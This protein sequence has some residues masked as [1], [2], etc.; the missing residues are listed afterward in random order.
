MCKLILMSYFID[1]L[2]VFALGL[3][4]GYC[5]QVGVVVG[6]CFARRVWLEWRD[7]MQVGPCCV[8][9]SFSWSIVGCL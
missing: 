8:F 2:F 7:V 6:L 3:D 9:G 5:W 1:C 4:G